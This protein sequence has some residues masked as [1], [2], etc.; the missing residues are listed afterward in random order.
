MTND[1]GK[2]STFWRFLH[3]LKDLQQSLQQP[4]S[5][6]NRLVKILDG[7]RVF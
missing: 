4:F 5:P 7:V 6:I 1:V 3:S 2:L